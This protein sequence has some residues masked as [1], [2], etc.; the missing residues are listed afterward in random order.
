MNEIIPWDFW[1]LV[2]NVT[3]PLLMGEPSANKANDGLH[4]GVIGTLL[5]NSSEFLLEIGCPL[6]AELA[7]RIAHKLRDSAWDYSD[8]AWVA[9][10]ESLR[11]AIRHELSRRRFAYI[12]ALY[13]QY[14]EQEKLFGAKVYDLF[15]DVRSDV[16]DVGNCIAG[17]LSTAAVFHAMRIAEHG[18]VSLASRLK[19]KL[20]DKGTPIAVTEATWSKIIVALQNQ[21]NSARLLP[22]SSRKRER[23][24]LYARAADQC[25]YLKDIWRNA[26][27][28]AHKTYTQHEALDAVHRVRD[29]MQHLATMM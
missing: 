20:R 17:E 19:V 13:D 2:H 15:P 10:M 21:I 1:T 4:S 12:P 9:D 16:K 5:Q 25:D 27:S 29:F 18:L 24:E 3:A 8:A 6:S 11:E 14:F 26:V 28:H 7:G 23:L 22:A